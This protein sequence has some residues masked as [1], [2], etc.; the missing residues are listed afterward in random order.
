MDGILLQERLPHARQNGLF[1]FLSYDT[2]QKYTDEDSSCGV[3]PS[4]QSMVYRTI[5]AHLLCRCTRLLM[6]L[7]SR[8]RSDMCSLVSYEEG[9]HITCIRKR[10]GAWKA[11]L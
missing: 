4:R 9:S 5:L 2:P 11:L 6:V 7:P 3:L 8:Q 1:L 10:S